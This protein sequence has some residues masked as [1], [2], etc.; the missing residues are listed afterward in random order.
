MFLFIVIVISIFIVMFAQFNQTDMTLQMMYTGYHFDTSF[1]AITVTTYSIGIV[2]GVLLMMRALFKSSK[3]HGKIRRKL[4]KTSVGADDS[5]LRVKTLENK[6]ATLESALKQSLQQ[7]KTA[8]QEEREK[9]ATQSASKTVQEETLEDM[10][11]SEEFDKEAE[12]E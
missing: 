10:D 8:A 9:S 4:E 11:A 3:E 1:L 5:D 2:S 7:N 12:D 6:I